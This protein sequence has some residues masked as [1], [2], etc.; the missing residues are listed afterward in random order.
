LFRCTPGLSRSIQFYLF[1][2]IQH[3]ERKMQ[4]VAKQGGLF[5]KKTAKKAATTSTKV[6][7]KKSRG[8]SDALWLPNTDRPAWL[9]GSLPGDRGFDPLGL[10]KPVEY[11][12][13]DVDQLD[14]NAA[15]NKAGRVIGTF[16]PV[17][18]EVSTDS[19]QPYSEVF[20]LQRFRECELIHGRWAMLGALGVLACE[21]STGV[22]WQDAISQEYAQ[23]AYANFDLPFDINQLAVAN[24]VL[25]GGVEFL[26]NTSTDPETRC[27]PGGVFDPLNL[28]SDNLKEAEIK[29][30]RLAMVACFGFAVQALAFGQG[31]LGSI[32]S[33]AN[34]F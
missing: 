19:L 1:H 8:S 17:V 15:V 13:V 20:G 16:T 25:M 23:P 4:I 26:R 9:D 5:G 12:Q 14:Q 21:F 33:F 7:V 24:S 22:A 18:D 32:E 3:R 30:G 27:Y 28:A 31:A 6:T 2:F 11:L 10:S 29:H 34:S